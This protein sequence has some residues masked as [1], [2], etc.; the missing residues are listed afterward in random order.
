[1]RR[2]VTTIEVTVRGVSSRFSH[3]SASAAFADAWRSYSDCYGCSFRDFMRVA[4][5]RTIPNPPGVGDPIRVLGRNAWALEPR[6]H[7]TRFV[8]ADGR[9]VMTAHHS[10]IQEGH[11]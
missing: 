6:R 10:D 1:M 5:R 8:Y 3:V 7:S 9:V 2:P 11:G 4:I